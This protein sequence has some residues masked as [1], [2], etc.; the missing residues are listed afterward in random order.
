V[1]LLNHIILLLAITSVLA[2]V[3]GARIEKRPCNRVKY[4]YAVSLSI[5][6]LL[7][8]LMETVEETEYGYAMALLVIL[9]QVLVGSVVRVLHLNRRPKEYQ[10]CDH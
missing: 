8:F 6:A 7:I 1:V 4:A 9:F 5:V 3:W 2:Q 10:D